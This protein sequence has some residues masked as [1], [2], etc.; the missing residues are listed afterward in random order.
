MHLAPQ[1]AER[2]D[3]AQLAAER[4]REEE[5]RKVEGEYRLRL[6][7]AVGQKWKGPFKRPDLER[8]A[9]WLDTLYNGAA[10][11]DAAFGE[12]AI[13]QLKDDQLVRHIALRLIAMD[14]EFCD[15][16][17]GRLLEAAQRFKIDA[18]KI[19]AEVV[20]DLKPVSAA[21]EKGG[22]KK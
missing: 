3:P 6:L 19:R 16:K 4:A 18:K 13:D 21:A 12:I 22:K 20:R 5:R 10:A 11:Y 14:C 2:A 1:G 15:G 7:K 9:E 17:P 8:I